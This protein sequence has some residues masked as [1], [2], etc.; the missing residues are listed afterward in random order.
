MKKRKL[1]SLS[2]FQRRILRVL[3]SQEQ[4]E[5]RYIAEMKK[6]Y[7]TLQRSLNKEI[8]S[9]IDRYAEND[10][11]TVEEAYRLLSKEE[12]HNWSLFVRGQTWVEKRIWKQ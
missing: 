8:A 3:V 6:R 10:G 4:R 1:S 7:S 5:D 12:I 11:I 9:W 2:Y